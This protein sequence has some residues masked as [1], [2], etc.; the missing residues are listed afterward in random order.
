[1]KGIPV[2]QI[3]AAQRALS[4]AG[5]FSIRKVE[6][7]L[8]GQ[9]LQQH[10][11]RHDFYFIL[12]LET[13]AGVHQI[14]FFPQPVTGRSVFLLRP[15]QV[16]QLV[17]KAGA[18]GYL[19]EYDAAFY[20]PLEKTAAQRFRSAGRIN[21]CLL[22]AGPFQEIHTVLSRIFEEYTL[23]QE[24]YREAIKAYLDLFYIAFTR[25]SHASANGDTPAG[26]YRQERFEEFVHLVEQHL[27]VRK[28]VSQYT[29]LMNLSLYQLNEITKTS[30]GKTASA[31]IDE[32]ILLEARRYL[33]AT[34]SQVKE[35]ADHLGFEDAS[36]FIRFFKKHTGQSPEAFRKNCT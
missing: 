34:P 32:Y 10:L 15:G 19:M 11:H 29:E 12:L 13:G 22:E 33:L 24:G 7:I 9:D 21:H 16:H 14:D 2:R 31:L 4:P 3:A 27:A 6:D 36:Y 28:R 30:V 25:Q 23:R 26:S 20:H 35:I 1:M 17:L 5:R 18:T 8:Q